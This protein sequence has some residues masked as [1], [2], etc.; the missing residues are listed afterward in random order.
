MTVYSKISVGFVFGCCGEQ[1]LLIKNALVL[2]L[3]LLRSRGC[4]SACSAVFASGCY[5]GREVVITFDYC[6][7]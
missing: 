3:A 6:N 7:K 1:E 4:T 2:E 5:G